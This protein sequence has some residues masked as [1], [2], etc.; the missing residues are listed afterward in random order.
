M[1]AMRICFAVLT[2]LTV[3]ACADDDE[4]Y[5]ARHRSWSSEQHRE[6]MYERQ[7]ALAAHRAWCDDHPSD[8]SCEGWYNRY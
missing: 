3:A 6:E 7:R 5:E 4:S 8:S 1:K 2:V